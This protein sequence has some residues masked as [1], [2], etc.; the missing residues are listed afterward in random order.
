MSEVEKIQN[1]WEEAR[2]SE[3]IG[4]LCNLLESNGKTSLSKLVRNAYEGVLPALKSGRHINPI[5]HTP[6]VAEFLVQI[7]LEEPDIEERSLKQGIVAAMFHDSGN[8][9]E[10]KSE[11]KIMKEDI[12]ENPSLR[13]LAIEQRARHMKNG[14]LLAERFMRAQDSPMF[15]EEDISVV[16][17]IIKHHDDP[18]IADLVDQK[19]RET[20]LFG[21]ESEHRCRLAAIHREAD[22][23]WMLS[24]DGL[25]T[26]MKRKA[27]KG[28]PWDPQAQITWNT[29]RHLEERAFYEE[30]FAT[31]IKEFNFEPFSAFY[32][33]KGGK[34]LFKVLQQKAREF[35]SEKWKELMVES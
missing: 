24:V 13:M 2:A 9:F 22:R 17:W 16:T 35:S 34:R 29:I 28:K 10:P 3:I 27:E 21:P 26:D 7:L 8:A 30:A 15:T 18:T 5:H 1:S 19:E 20:Y 4:R 14:A 12:D 25:V 33:T 6:Y 31:K 23:L 11:K 32:R